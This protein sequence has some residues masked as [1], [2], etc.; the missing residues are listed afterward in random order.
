[1]LAETLIAARKW[2]SH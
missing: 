2:F 1:M